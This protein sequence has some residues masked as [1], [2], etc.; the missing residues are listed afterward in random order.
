M[1]DVRPA[2]ELMTAAGRR[3]LTRVS[4]NN[5]MRRS[6]SVFSLTVALAIGATGA[7][8]IAGAQ[9]PAAAGP[10][11]LTNEQ[12]RQRMM[13]LLKITMFPP[14]AVNS[15]AVTYDES[16]ANPYP[17]LPD[18]LKMNDGRKVTSQA[19]WRQRR[20]ELMELFDREVYG[21]T[22]KVTPKVTWQVVST[23]AEENGGVPVVTKQL[24]GHVDNS[25][26]PAITVDILLSLSTPARAQ[27]P[28]PVVMQFGG[29]FGA[30]PAGVPAPPN[31][32]A[33]PAAAN[34]PA[35]GGLPTRAGGAGAALPGAARG[36][37]GP[38]W[39]Q[40]VL[41][42]GW[43]YATLVPASIQAD[44]GAGLTQGIIGLVN[45]GQPRKPDDWGSL[46]ALAWGAS[47]ALDYFESDKAV[48]ARR[49]AVEG[50]SRWGKATLVTLAYDERFATGYVSSSGQGGA[51]LHRRKYGETIENLVTNFPYWMA[52]NYMKYAGHWDMLPVDSH[53]LIALVAPRPIFISGGRGPTL[54]P[55]GTIKLRTE[56]AREGASM[57]PPG[58]VEA[59][60]DAWVD[61]QGSFLA[62]VGAGPVYKL[63]GRK[64]LGTT[65]FPPIETG[66]TDGDIAFRQHGGGHTDGPNWP[67]FLD[68]AA[69]Y[70]RAA[71]R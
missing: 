69:R 3:Q 34:A 67:T 58:T 16:K 26:Y 53:E 18:P 10:V 62:A 68:F 31:P 14:G 47:R 55:D 29:G 8:T 57:P 48:D 54:N 49:V 71:P 60:N 63:L 25:A 5:I 70:F 1:G 44:C 59:A 15:L 52:G 51:K 38:T 4:E 23:T 19:M 2:A 40:Q 39:Q 65:T 13:D 11:Q 56:P 20:L 45:K 50:H 66:L 36:P 32:C 33:P 41:A 27:G 30:P 28:V 42:K 12:D 24:V 7:R 9:G 21:R 22:P 35:R 61:P 17:D 43:G 6:L 46:K 64:D 37:Q